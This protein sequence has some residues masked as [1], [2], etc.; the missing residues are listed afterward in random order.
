M[1]HWLFLICF[2][3][4]LIVAGCGGSAVAGPAGA[5]TAG[6]AGAPTLSA[7]TGGAA[8]ELAGAPGAGGDSPYEFGGSCT[9]S[10]DRTC[11]DHPSEPGKE[12]AY[13]EYLCTTTDGTWAT[14]TL[15]P[16]T[17]RIGGCRVV[18]GNWYVVTWYY[19]AAAAADAKATCVGTWIFS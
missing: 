12:A 3:G 7:G 19:D 15:C 10:M 16:P 18:Y 17:D 2:C 11:V 6:E 8:A 9:F 13:D 14:A 4:S 5:G 1:K